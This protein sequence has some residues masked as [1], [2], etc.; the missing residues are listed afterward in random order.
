MINIDTRL[1]ETLESDELYTICHLAKYLGRDLSCFPSKGTLQSDTGFGRK[2]LDK[3]ISG[4]VDKGHI[5]KVQRK[6][7]K[8]KFQSN[9]Y[10][11]TTEF[12]SVFISAKGKSVTVVPK[13]DNGESV[14]GGTDNGEGGNKVLSNSSE[15]LSS[16]E[17]LSNK[18]EH[19]DESAPQIPYQ[20]EKKEIPKSKN[21]SQRKKV[22]PKKEIQK[23]TKEKPEIHLAMDKMNE[24]Y[25][26]W[27]KVRGIDDS[28]KIDFTPKECKQ[29]S[30]LIRKIR[31]VAKDKKFEY[32]TNTDFINGAF[33]EFLTAYIFITK[34]YQGSGAGW[35]TSSFKPSQMVSNY[36]EIRDTFK[37]IR[38]GKGK[39]NGVTDDFKQKQF[40]ILNRAK[41]A[42]AS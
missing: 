19:A 38:N 33:N 23:P 20:P 37:L 3:S 25:V 35:Y 30:S 8:G 41:R 5:E 27:C 16:I 24:R 15:V 9:I 32:R 31:S 18:E 2:R 1:L 42:Y 21:K 36:Q 34:S 28:D 40:D 17:V 13:S 7:N 39:S 14:N 4:L 12:I 29:L 22:A 26:D 11:F 10:T 6:Q